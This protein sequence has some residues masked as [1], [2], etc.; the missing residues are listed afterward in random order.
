MLKDTYDE[1]FV[2]E[3]YQLPVVTFEE[4]RGG[5]VQTKGPV[6]I[7]YNNRNKFLESARNLGI[8]DDFKV[9]FREKV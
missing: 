2:K 1:K 3:L 8:M 6:R 5:L 7:Q 4:L 9:S